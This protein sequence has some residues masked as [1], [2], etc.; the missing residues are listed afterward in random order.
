[1]E[2][3]NKTVRTRRIGSVTFGISLILFGVLFLGKLLFPA[4]KYTFIFHLWPVVFIMLG[5][6]ILIETHRDGI[7]Y[8]YDKAAIFMML[9]L[10]VFVMCMGAADWCVWH[11]DHHWIYAR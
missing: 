11:Y 10:L 7:K 3:T 4:L 5:L 2:D 6:E 1:M 8:V 9:L